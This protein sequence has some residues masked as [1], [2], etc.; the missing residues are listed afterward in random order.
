MIYNRYIL[1]LIHLVVLFLSV[2]TVDAQVRISDTPVPITLPQATATATPILRLTPTP[3]FTPTPE[4]I[5]VVLEAAVPASETLV[6]DFPE[7]GN[8]IGFLEPGEQYAVIG[9]YFSWILFE[10]PDTPDGRG[11]IFIPTIRFIGDATTIPFVDPNLPSEDDPN[12]QS[13]LTAIAQLQ[14]PGVAESATANARIVSIATLSIENQN[15]PNNDRATFTPPAE[16]IL[17]VPTINPEEETPD[18]QLTR[19][20]DD[21]SIPPLVPILLLAMGGALGLFISALRR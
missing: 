17:R 15:N 11:W 12:A 14:T 5:S 8:Y 10:F 7:T 4:P 21:V 13:T 20:P 19:L 2:A 3:T 6:L 9:Q 18:N 16:I 1:H